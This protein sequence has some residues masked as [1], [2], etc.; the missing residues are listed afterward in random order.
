MEIIARR[1]E[2]LREQYDI[3]MV[4]TPPMLAVTDPAIV[5]RNVD[6]VVLCIRLNKRSR[7]VAIRSAQM[8]SQMDA[9]VMGIVVNGVDPGRHSNY[10]Y[11][12]GYGNYYGSGKGHDSMKAQPSASSKSQAAAANSPATVP[13]PTSAPAKRRS[14]A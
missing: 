12:Y 14:S 13:T 10:Y 6:G 1:L 7:T 11:T 8:L 9:N 2:I 4:D 3:V 5:A